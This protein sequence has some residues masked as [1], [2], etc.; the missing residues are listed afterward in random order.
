MIRIEN[1]S[2]HYGEQILFMDANL[3]LKPG[4]RYGL[5]G[6]NGSGKSTFVRLLLEKEYPSF[7]EIIKSNKTSITA[8]EQDHFKYEE[9][10]IIDVVIMGKKALWQ[11]IKAKN[12]ILDKGD[13]ITEDD[14][15][16]LA[17]YEEI[18]ADNDGY[19]A[20]SEAQIILNGLG[21]ESSYHF[22]PLSTLSGGL[23]LR[24]LMAKCLFA[25]P[26]YMLL[27][28]PS[29]HLDIVAIK[30]LENYLLNKYQ[31]TLILISHDHA[32]ISNIC[33]KILDIDYGEIR[34]YSGTYNH[35]QT[36]KE[37]I[38]IQ[39][40]AEYENKSKQIAKAKVFIERFRASANRSRQALS[41]EK[42]IN[43]VELPKIVPSSRRAPNISFQVNRKTGKIALEVKNLAKHYEEKEIF[44]KV[45]FKINRGDK[46]AILGKNGA[47]KTTLLK[48]LL[49]IEK[50]NSGTV[51]FGAGA[52][53][54]YFSQDH[55][56][57][58]KEDYNAL[59]WLEK[60][61]PEHSVGEIRKFMGKMLFTQDEALKH[62]SVLSG[63]ESARLLVTKLMLEKPNVIIL[64]E[65]TNHLDLEA[66]DNLQKALQKYEGTVIFVS[67]DRDFIK[68]TANRIIYLENKKITDIVIGLDEFLAEKLLNG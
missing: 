23:K 67:H 25:N 30:W 59:E 13:H 35:F 3:A 57:L 17:E 19:S 49:G 50:P 26:N 68:A 43:K 46:L 51:T 7:G 29:N 56:D 4:H 2:M 10:R 14:C 63:G 62:L 40:I 64:D 39:K 65:P 36:Q 27:D 53:I 55:H 5:L 32:L 1:L 60:Q 34:E 8:L 28:E 12:T 41:R 21:I 24:V 61:L 37:L 54:G 15:Y 22:L 11:A 45:S 47:G 38:E 6:P 16:A 18:I 52:K 33:D 44:N 9:E 31:G 42:Q 20:E 66:I 48:S 58:L